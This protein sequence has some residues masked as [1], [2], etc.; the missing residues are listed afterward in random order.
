M[1]QLRREGTRSPLAHQIEVLVNDHSRFKVDIDGGHVLP[2]QRHQTGEVLLR[3]GKDDTTQ[4]RV[5]QSTYMACRVSCCVSCGVSCVVDVY[6]AVDDLVDGHLL[7]VVLRVVL[8]RRLAVVCRGKARQLARW[9]RLLLLACVVCACVR[10]S[11]RFVCERPQTVCGAVRCVW[12][13][14]TLVNDLSEVEALVERG[15]TVVRSP[16]VFVHLR[17]SANVSLMEN[18]THTHTRRTRTRTRKRIMND[19]TLVMGM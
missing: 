12:P 6:I 9:H 17:N 5:S 10:V 2:H 18:R 3:I 15:S 19:G 13:G 14:R 16:H 8:R 11:C 7:V 1:M 4:A